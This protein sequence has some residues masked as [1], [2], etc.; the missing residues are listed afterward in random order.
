VEEGARQISKQQFSLK[1]AVFWNVAPCRNASVNTIST[2]CHI[3]EDCFLHS[4]RRENL[5]SYNNLVCLQLI[6]LLGLLLDNVDV[7]STFIRNVVKLPDYGI[8]YL[9]GPT[10]RTSNPQRE[11]LQEQKR[12]REKHFHRV[13]MVMAPLG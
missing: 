11:K 4:H 9:R 3:Q 5:K 12:E 13:T 10:L 2:R 1:K 6:S 7:G 8:L